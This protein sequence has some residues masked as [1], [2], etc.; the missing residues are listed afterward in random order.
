MCWLGQFIPVHI[1]SNSCIEHLAA[2]YIKK[3]EFIKSLDFWLFLTFGPCCHCIFCWLACSPHILSHCSLLPPSCL[4]AAH[5]PSWFIFS[6]D[7]LST[8]FSDVYLPKAREDAWSYTVSSQYTLNE[9]TSNSV[10]VLSLSIVLG[11]SNGRKLGCH[12][13]GVCALSSYYHIRVC[14]IVEKGTCM[15]F[16]YRRANR[17]TQNEDLCI[18][19][20]TQLMFQ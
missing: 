3:D 17:T 14:V 15:C 12:S 11:L 8:V 5:Y 4:R 19:D 16:I 18:L 9:W 2:L 6:V 1:I 20:L 13:F 7:T 10:S